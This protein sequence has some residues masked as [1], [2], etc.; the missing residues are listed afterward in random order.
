MDNENEMNEMYQRIMAKLDK[1]I[2]EVDDYS[3]DEIL[4]I[5]RSGRKSQFDRRRT[6]TRWTVAI[7]L[8]LL[9][10]SML[11][12]WKLPWLSPMSWIAIVIGFLSLWVSIIGGYDL[13]LF[14][15]IHRY[16]Y[17]PDKTELFASR[18]NRRTE[19]RNR[20]LRFVVSNPQPVKA[21]PHT[22]PTVTIQWSR[23]AGIAAA[24]LLFLTVAIL[25]LRPTHNKDVAPLMAHQSKE[26][27][28]PTAQTFDQFQQPVVPIAKTETKPTLTTEKP[29]PLSV[30]EEI[31]PATSE[32]QPIQENIENQYFEYNTVFS[33]V[34]QEGSMMTALV[35]CNKSCNADTIISE[36]QK[37]V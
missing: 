1:V 8:A 18:L 9:I 34:Q 17:N 36:C 22:A 24:F 2:D 37:I 12:L 33:E 35:R 7:A 3:D 32:S 15:M 14:R 13:Y 31:A 23:L 19:R 10:A 11:V 6:A 20:L 28:E 16:R 27:T 5:I 26:I 29:V 30:A 21:Q 25:Y 4:A